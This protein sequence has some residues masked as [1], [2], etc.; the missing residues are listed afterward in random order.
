MI[1]KCY[2]ISFLLP[3][4][5]RI[6]RRILYYTYTSR[7]VKLWIK[8][9]MVWLSEWSKHKKYSIT[10]FKTTEPKVFCVIRITNDLCCWLATSHHHLHDS[11]LH[12]LHICLSQSSLLVGLHLHQPYLHFLSLGS[13]RRAE[14]FSLLLEIVEPFVLFVRKIC[15]SAL[16]GRVSLRHHLMS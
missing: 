10:S 16:F 2:C 3:S 13:V 12:L 7:E 5:N 14:I 11:A 1:L 6:F 8:M 9:G 4:H 15:D